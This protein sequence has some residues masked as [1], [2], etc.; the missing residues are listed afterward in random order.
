MNTIIPVKNA[1]DLAA[2]S[3]QEVRLVCNPD[4]NFLL[5]TIRKSDTVGPIRSCLSLELPIMPATDF[6]TTD[7][8]FPPTGVVYFFANSLNSDLPSTIAHD[9]TVKVVGSDLTPSFTTLT[10]TGDTT[11][12][13]TLEM[14]GTVHEARQITLDD[15]AEFGLLYD[16]DSGVLLIGSV[17][18]TLT[19]LSLDAS[20]MKFGIKGGE[21]IGFFNTTPITKP[22]L[23]AAAP[24]DTA[25]LITQVTA[26]KTLL[27]NLGLASL[28]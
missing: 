26:I 19:T 28:T 21:K 18:G 20:E 8:P 9:G 1:N 17:D 6:G 16:P 10:V 12:G 5:F 14:S 27:S 24:T 13:P 11:L 7:F 4:A 25:T 23:T 2:P 15:D 3:S 22:T